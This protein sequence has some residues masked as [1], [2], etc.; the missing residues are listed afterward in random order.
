VVT[1]ARQREVEVLLERLTLWAQRQAD[2]SALALVGSWAR[3]AAASGSDVDLVLLTGGPVR[4]T[5]SDAW[6][7]ELGGER[8]TRTLAWGPV[9]ERRFVL[10]SGLEVELG[11][12]TPDW[13]AVDPVDPGT[14]RV[15]SDG[16][17]ILHD[18]EGLL[19]AL[20]AAC[21]CG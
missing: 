14:Q 15:I 12:A 10:P 4:F 5:D 3:D 8:L 20:A 17:R 9:T 18:P 6:L 16:M 13:A 1:E 7:P 21:G 19:A 11:V 2:I